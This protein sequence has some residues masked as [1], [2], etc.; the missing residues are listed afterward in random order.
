MTESMVDFLSGAI[1]LGFGLSAVFF[2][3]FWQRT[4]DRLFLA[5]AIAFGLLGTGQIIQVFAD[6]AQEEQSYIYLIRLAAFSTILVAIVI[7]NRKPV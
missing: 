3:K 1:S 7:K 5:F 2:L 6:I 4:Q